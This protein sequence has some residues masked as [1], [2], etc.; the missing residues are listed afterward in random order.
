[1]RYFTAEMWR[2][3]NS[4]DDDEARRWVE[5]MGRAGEAYRQQLSPLVERL[6]K[7]A[8]EFFD[9]CRH[10]LH[11]G[12]VTEWITGGFGDRNLPNVTLRVRSGGVGK[13]EY[14]DYLYELRYTSV[15]RL[16]FERPDDWLFFRGLGTWGYDELT[17][18]G[19]GRFQ[20]A[21]LFDSGA[22]LELVFDR[23]SW[24]RRLFTPAAT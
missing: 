6:P 22:T 12:S 18:A 14:R 8:A 24:R 19:A 23:F 1:M 16:H 17:G 15:S 21:V 9:T 3:W 13:Q 7:R 2:G 10:S 4:H 11:D 5:H 20:H